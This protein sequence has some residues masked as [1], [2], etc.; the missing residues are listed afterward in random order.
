MIF[1]SINGFHLSTY[2]DNLKEHKIKFPFNEELHGP[3]E[4]G[5][6]GRRRTN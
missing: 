6:W 4:V 3:L 5:G 1:G 2:C